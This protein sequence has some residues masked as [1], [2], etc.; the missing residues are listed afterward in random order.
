LKGHFWNQEITHLEVQGLK[1]GA[2]KLWVNC[3]NLVHSPTFVHAVL[4]ARDFR[5]GHEVRLGVAAQVAFEA[6]FETGFSLDRFDA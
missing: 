2:F 1:P 3:I 4:D 6:N 5:V